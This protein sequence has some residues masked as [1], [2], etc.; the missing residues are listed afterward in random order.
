[1][2]SHGRSSSWRGYVGLSLGW[3]VVLG[4]VL[5]L[6]RRPSAQPIEILPPPTLPPTATPE[7]SPT[8]AP[9]R[10]DVSG[11]VHVPGVYTLP[12][13]SIVADAIAAAGG[14]TAD[15]ALDAINK[16]VQL[17][18]GMQIRVPSI[19]AA[20]APLLS[21]P[22]LLMTAPQPAVTA[23]TA[24]EAAQPARLIDLNTATPAELET[25]PGVGPAT[26]Q[27]IIDGRPYSA[28]EDLLRVKGIGPATFEKLK[29]H[30]TVQ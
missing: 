24:E 7:P 12:P 29:D 27:R 5:L 8:P 20:A 6:T 25:L 3:L 16:A 4:V 11:A 21:N 30:I 1:M 9:I 14:A 13:G 23:S 2:Q 17:Q 28:I 22:V 15:A 26:A 19:E 18:D 10:V